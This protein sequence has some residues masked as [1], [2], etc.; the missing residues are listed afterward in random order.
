[1]NS[2]HVWQGFKVGQA[3][4]PDIMMTSG[5]ACPTILQFWIADFRLRNLDF[6]HYY[7]CRSIGGV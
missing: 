1:M 7:F 6:E 3:S 2:K 5:D 4:S